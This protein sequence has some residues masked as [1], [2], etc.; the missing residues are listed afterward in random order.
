MQKKT[1]II[2]AVAALVVILAGLVG[3]A[4]LNMK[5]NADSLLPFYGTEGEL[6][7]AVNRTFEADENAPEGMVLVK[8]NNKIALYMS[9]EDCS[10]AVYDYS[11]KETWYSTPPGSD[12]DAIAL[13]DVKKRIKSQL[14]IKYYTEKSN[15][16]YMDSYT[17]AI[18]QE[19]FE[20]T[21]IENGV[22]VTYTIGK[23]TVS[24]DMLPTVISKKRFENLILEKIEDEEALAIMNARYSLVKIDDLDSGRQKIYKGFYPTVDTSKELYFLKTN[25]PIYA[26][27]DIYDVLN[28]VGYT[29]ADIQ[30]DNEENNL[31]IEVVDKESFVIPVEYTI[32]DDQFAARVITSKIEEP[33]TFTL[34]GINVL[35]FFGAGGLDDEGYMF[36]PDGSGAIVNFNNGKLDAPS[37]NLLVY[38]EDKSFTKKEGVDYTPADTLVPV[39]G[40]NKNNKSFLAIVDSGEA[41]AS[42]CA[43]ISEKT[44][45]FNQ[46]Y[47][48]F[49]IR[50]YD[51][52][53]VSTNKGLRYNN[54]Y[55]EARMN[56]D[57]SVR[58]LFMSDDQQGYVGMANA[59]KDYLVENGELVKKD[60]SD[61]LFVTELVGQVEA[62][63]FTLGIPSTVE[64]SVTS[65]DEAKIIVEELYDKG[66]KNPTIKYTSWTKGSGL[67]PKAASK[68]KVSSSLGGKKDLINLNT[69]LAT[70]GASLSLNI[71]INNVYDSIP[72]FNK[73]SYTNRLTYNQ[74]SNQRFYNVATLVASNNKYYTLS[75]RYLKSYV[76]EYLKKIEKTN[77]DNLWFEDIASDLNSDFRKKKNVDRQEVKRLTVETLGYIANETTEIGL[78][79]PNVYA[80][81]YADKLVDLP[82]TTSGHRM[83]DDS[84]PFIQI[85]LS[86][87]ISYTG[88]VINTSGKDRVDMLKA[89]ETGAGLYF[90]W[91]Y[92][93]NEDV[94]DMLGEE[95]LGLYSLYYKDWIDTAASYYDE[96]KNDVGHLLG[97]EIKNHE[98][99][100]YNVYKTTYEKG[101]V[102]VNYNDYD[103]EINGETVK[104]YDFK[105]ID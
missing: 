28:S 69:D 4:A 100:E 3:A 51:V 52:M 2:I 34:T 7:P 17:Y 66:I 89:V 30:T 15:V 45:S 85:V 10:L 22:R 6:S 92:S 43:D 18:Q 60:T 59:Y 99:L 25:C 5:L 20:I 77:V 104:A 87:T 63:K 24:K 11:T 14:Y 49:N 80:W 67:Y 12:D 16:R 29:S 31:D 73:W 95:P 56:D 39:F 76:E 93:N 71:N 105:V 46:A 8:K 53:V 86:G 81:K 103:V 97:T 40:I 26:Y 38:G 9:E 55:Q 13:G 68:A 70:L 19:Q 21:P 48:T 1:K 42:I 58:Y 37:Y 36:V 75:A 61:I 41:H 78:D 57:C 50:P 84:V 44:H 101:S 33:S 79:K 65:F 88:E 94:K 91:I 47:A 72:N 32:E 54:K 90:K 96:M 23:D 64:E 27:A 98:K 62:K 83:E 102:I 82:L 74:I 35:E